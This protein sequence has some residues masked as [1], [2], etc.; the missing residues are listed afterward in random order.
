MVV[1]GLLSS[2]VP[3]LGQLY[4]GATRRGLVLLGIAVAIVVGGLVIGSRL[5]LDALPG[6]DRRIVAIVLLVD[7]ALLAFRLFAVVD[8]A[9]GALPV[10]VA[11]LV[12]LTA[13]PRRGPPG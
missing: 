13:A 12:A 7:L 11:A 2:V 5:S 9:R 4:R 3:G 8:A 1:A 6:V 10:L